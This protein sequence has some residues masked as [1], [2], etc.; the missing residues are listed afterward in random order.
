MTFPKLVVYLSAATFADFGA[1]LM[2]APT[3]LEDVAS[4]GLSNPEA[5]AEIR[6]MY[7]GLEIGIAAFLHWCAPSETR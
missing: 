4:V 7:G 1:W 2:L 5:R 6:A 3:A